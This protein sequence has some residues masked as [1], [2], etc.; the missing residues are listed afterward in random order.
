M[1]KRTGRALAALTMAAVLPLLAAC[2]NNGGVGGSSS[3]AQDE[4][5]PVTLNYWTWY[6]DENS[7]QPAIDAFEAANPDITVKL[8][9]FTNTDYQTQL[10]LALNGGESLD[11]VGVQVSAMTNVVKDQLR[12][13]EEYADDLGSGYPNDLDP[14]IL[15]QAQSA[16]DD[17][18]LYDI[19]MGAISSSILYYNAATLDAAG[20]AVPQTAAELAEAAATLKAQGQA[21]P[22]V[23][24]G[25]GWWQEEVLFSI[26]GQ[27]D[28][29]VSDSIFLGDGSWDQPAIVNGLKAYKSLFDSGAIDTSV[30]SLTGSAPAEQFTSGQSAFLIDGAWQASLLSSAY[31]EANNIALTDVGAVPLPI[32]TSGGKPAVRGLAEG[33]LAIPKSSTHVAAAAKFIAYMTFGDGVEIWDKNLVLVP[34]AKVAFTPDASTLTTQAAKDGFAAIQEVAAQPGSERTSQQDFL[35]KVEGPTILDVLRGNITP[36]DAAATL[37]AEWKSGRYPKAGS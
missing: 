5:G 27:T 20:I 19:P 33:G 12:P 34:T 28:P 16:A 4:S 24:T 6:P 35:G 25:D 1:H 29:D 3:A 22:V 18:V 32:V 37:Q 17:N 31:R 21:T 10:P 2:G 30:L 8:R 9:I 36:E 14:Q 15:K 7:L 23:Q 26:I 13:V 11:V